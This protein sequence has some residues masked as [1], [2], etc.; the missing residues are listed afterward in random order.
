F[1]KSRI[2]GKF[3]FQFWAMF[4]CNAVI[5]QLFWFKKVRQSILMLF[6]ISIFINIGM[7]YE[8]FNI[9]I[10]SLSNDYLPANWADYKPTITEIGIY[11]GTLGIFIA[12][13]LLFFRYIPMLAISELK[14]VNKF[15]KPGHGKRKIAR[16]I[17]HG[18]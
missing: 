1:F 12:G 5:P 7:W 16:D 8:R 11:V 15:N 13:V 6:I 3:S 10:T 9:V 14:G 18:R 4:I 2:T 17:Q